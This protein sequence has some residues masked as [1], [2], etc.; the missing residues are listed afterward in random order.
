MEDLTKTQMILLCLLVSFVTSIGTGV[1]TFSLLSEAPQT[2]T[3]T[4]NRV[5]ERTIEKVVPSVDNEKTTTKEI[6]TVVVKEEDL[7]ID[8]ISKNA[9]SVVRIKSGPEKTFYGLGLIIDTDGLIV[10]D[11]KGFN[12]ENK[13]EVVISDNTSFEI[14]AVDAKVGDDF[15]FFKIKKE[16]GDKTEFAPAVFGNSDGLQLGQSVIAISGGAG[17][18][19]VSTGRISALK[20]AGVTGASAGYINAIETDLKLGDG[21]TGGP[22]LN[23]SGQVVG[24][25]TVSM[26]SGINGNFVPIALIK[27]AISLIESK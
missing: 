10:T 21:A 14:S 4:I 13:Y 22:L 17:D 18:A 23:L 2:V 25:S 1:I 19:S 9:K 8:A 5:V 7:I 15:M 16:D 24:L 20:R 11:A 6:T 26:G 3:Q 27:T 12:P